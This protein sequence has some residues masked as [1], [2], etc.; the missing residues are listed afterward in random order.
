MI[1]P[2]LC[3]NPNVVLQIVQHA[4]VALGSVSGDRAQFGNGIVRATSALHV[5][6]LRVT[7]TRTTLLGVLHLQILSSL[8]L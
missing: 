3:F 7:R 2:Y 1:D 8:A 6:L 4:V 5:A